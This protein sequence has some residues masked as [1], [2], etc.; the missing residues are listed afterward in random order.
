M[1]AQRQTRSEEI[2]N[3]L[4]HSVGMA[5]GLTAIIVL[6]IAG[7]YNGSPWVMVS[8]SIY[9]LSMTLSYVTSTFYH[10]STN[11]KQK[12]ML[13]RFDHA[14]IY[15]HIAGTYTPFTLITLREEGFWGWGLFFVVW[16]AAA[17]GVWLSFRKMKRNSSLK[18]VCYLLMGWVVIIAVKPLITVFQDT[19][20]MAVFYWLVAGGLFYSIG[21]IFFF[22]DKYA[23]RLAFICFGRKYLSFYFHI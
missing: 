12:C 7:I 9:A 18:T 20:M 10:A 1:T 15:L 19:D 13:R 17:V 23:F 4:T 22:L 2:T 8:F 21:T 6:I 11:A 3:V 16:I 5:L 14:A